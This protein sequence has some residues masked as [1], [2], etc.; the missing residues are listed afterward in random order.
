MSSDETDERRHPALVATAIALPVAL[1]AGV[2]VAAVLATRAPEQGPVALGTVPAPDAESADCTSLLG[3]LPD[4]FDSFT[5]A[6]LVDPAPPGAAAWHSPDVAE[7]VVLRC[8]LE[9]PAEFDQASRLDV[10]DDVQWFPVSGDAQGIDATTWYAV[11]RPVYV[12]LTVPTGTG[13]TP[14]QA[15]TAVVSQ[16]LAAGPLDPNPIN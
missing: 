7:P 13:P 11:D 6:A 3:A 1:V 8:G 10:I 5:R 14:L 9:R 12:A 2:I 16:T 4:A 15:I